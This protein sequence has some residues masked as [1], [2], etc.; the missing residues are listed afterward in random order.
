MLI[1][2][3]FMFNAISHLGEQ[4]AYTLHIG[5]KADCNNNEFITDNF[6]KIIEDE[7]I[8]QLHNRN[9]N[10]IYAYPTTELIAKEIWQTLN[11]ADFLPTIEIVRLWE[12]R[13][14]WVEINR[15]DMTN[16]VSSIL[17]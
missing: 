13:T 8:H 7:I 12:T 14:S 17:C 1:F 4:T 3:E 15:Q 5:I 16:G 9:L 6:T 2:K 10:D 11:Q